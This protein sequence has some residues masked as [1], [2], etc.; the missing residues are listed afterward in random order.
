MKPVEIKLSDYKLFG[1]GEP[2]VIILQ[3][4]FSEAEDV[5][6]PLPGILQKLT[7]VSFLF[8]QF[9]VPHPDDLLT[10]WPAPGLSEKRPFGGKASETLEF[11]TGDLL[12]H[13]F[14]KIKLPLILGGYSLAGLFALWCAYQTD[15]F[16]AVVSVSPSLWYDKWIE[17]ISHRRPL[18]RNI[19]LSLGI[20]E[21]KGRN[22]R[23][24][25]VG[26][27]IRR[28]DILLDENAGLNHI[29]EWNPGNHFTEPAS[30]MVRGYEWTIKSLF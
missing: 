16:D 23:L 25:T 28:Q 6:E 1:P 13:I 18:T 14:G 22:R 26:E 15:A 27:N 17:Y 10:P 11:I 2:Q 12:P 4:A 24:A 29:L 3:P 8:C 9:I 30:R 20:E 5:M 19:Y 7:G 21:P